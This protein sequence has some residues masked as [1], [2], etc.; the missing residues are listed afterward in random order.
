MGLG[1]KLNLVLLIVFAFGLALFY[2]LSEPFL[3][4]QAREEVLTRARIMMESAAGTRQY[5]AR[6]VA[7]LLTAQ[8]KSTFHPQTVAAYAAMKNFEVMRTNYPDYSYREAALNPTNPAHRAVEWEADI[9]ND[10]RA[11]PGKRDVVTYRDT[12]QGRFAHLSRP[13]KVEERCLVCHSRWEA[14]P[15]SLI[16]AYGRS[17]GFGWKRDEIIGAQIVSVP[18]AL[19]LQHAHQT[20]FFF[21]KLLAAVFLLLA[22][23]LN[24]LLR[25]VVLNPIQRMSQIA[26]DVSMGKSDVP[27]YAKPGSDEIA[28]LSA[29]FNRMRR[30]VEEAMKMLGESLKK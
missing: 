19:A 24:I 25:A 17:N 6:E 12:A 9:I 28:S 15:R 16:V 30:T 29:S 4:K 14:A 13:I 22:I 18:M 11:F 7:P 23:P 21:M 26:G 20:R 5:T 8:M 10:F 1:L 2:F 27:E 3:E